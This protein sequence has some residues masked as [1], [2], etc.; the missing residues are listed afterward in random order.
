MN[1]PVGEQ[2]EYFCTNAND[3]MTI[4]ST[5]S[6]LSR[7]PECDRTF[8]VFSDLERKSVKITVKLKEND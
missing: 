1:I 6:Q 8:S 3:V 5:A 4:R 7:D 2:M